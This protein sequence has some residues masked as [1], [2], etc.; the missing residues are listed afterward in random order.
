MAADTFILAIQILTSNCG[1]KDDSLGR[2]FATVRYGLLWSLLSKQY[3]L[4]E[5][6]LIHDRKSL[7]QVHKQTFFFKWKK[8]LVL[9]E[10][11]FQ[12]SYIA[13]FDWAS[14]LYPY[15]CIAQ[16]GNSRTTTYA[17]IYQKTIS[18]LKNIWR[19]SPEIKLNNFRTTKLYQTSA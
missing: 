4:P 15:L 2:I 11:A 3:K 7:M 6:G 5:F 17:L 1:H 8:F 10:N 16:L 19:M 14:Y 13:S 12:T 9:F 18:N